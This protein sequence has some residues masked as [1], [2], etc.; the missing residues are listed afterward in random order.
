MDKPSKEEI[1]EIQEA[2]EQ[3]MEAMG[4]VII[5]MFKF[6][7]PMLNKYFMMNMVGQITASLVSSGMGEDEIVQTAVRLASKAMEEVHSIHE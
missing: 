7:D 1:K 2:M 4:P 6:Y 5:K 3:T